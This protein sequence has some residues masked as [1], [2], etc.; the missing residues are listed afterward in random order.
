[1]GFCEQLIKRKTDA[2]LI[3]VVK[4]AV[5]AIFF[6]VGFLINFS[7]ALLVL[8]LAVVSHNLFLN[9]EY[10]YI[11]A[12]GELDIDVIYNKSR[13]K[14]AFSA[15]LRDFQPY[16]GQSARVVKNFSSGGGGNTLAFFCV[17]NGVPTKIIIEPNEEMLKK[18]KMIIK[19]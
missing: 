12:D 15:A 11:L 1:M 13:R 9:V 10:E 2:R 7:I 4:F 16:G 14:R 5:L 17:Y 3:A 8:P 19:F 6:A 18:L